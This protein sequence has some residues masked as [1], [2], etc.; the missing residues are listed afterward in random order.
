MHAGKAWLLRLAAALCATR[1]QA[2]ATPVGTKVEQRR[3]S[4]Y[5]APL[6]IETVA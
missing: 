2:V 3:V 1:P 4:D 6:G 5:D